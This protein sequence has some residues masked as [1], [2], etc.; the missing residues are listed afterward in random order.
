MSVSNHGRTAFESI[1]TTFPL[2]IGISGI[3]SS[4]LGWIAIGQ[5]LLAITAVYLIYRAREHSVTAGILGG[6]GI[7]TAIV[8]AQYSLGRA[9][10]VVSVEEMVRMIV[11]SVICGG[12]GLALAATAL[13]P[14]ID[15][16]DPDPN[17]TRTHP[18]EATN[19]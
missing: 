17:T 10:F 11:V 18:E 12:I 1:G 14:E 19:G 9:L 5:F 13:E 6:I 7:P 16:V 4:E 8:A 3:E 15:E 2:D